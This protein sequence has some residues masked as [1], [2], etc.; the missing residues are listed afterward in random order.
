MNFY[1][2][3]DH[4]SVIIISKRGNFNAY[5]YGGIMQNRMRDFF[6]DHL[7]DEYGMNVTHESLTEHVNHISIDYLIGRLKYSDFLN[8]FYG[9][10]TRKYYVK[11]L[12]EC[13]DLTEVQKRMIKMY[14]S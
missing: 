5:Y 2:R 3:G 7:M 12:L 4:S 9:T 10:N 1:Y 8:P 6:P 14:S 13:H 11:E